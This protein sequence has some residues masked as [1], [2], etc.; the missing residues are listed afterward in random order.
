MDAARLEC[1]YNFQD[2]RKAE[3]VQDPACRVAA[4]HYW[5]EIFSEM[6]CVV[7]LLLFSLHASLPIYVFSSGEVSRRKDS[8]NSQKSGPV[9]TFQDSSI[10]LETGFC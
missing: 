4:H 10:G 1:D 7:S 3:V 5:S 6:P 8:Q 2:L 9:P